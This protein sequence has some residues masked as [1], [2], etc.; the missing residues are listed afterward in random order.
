MFLTILTEVYDLQSILL[1]V[2]NFYTKIISL[3]KNSQ[4]LWIIIQKYG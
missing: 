4:I 3:L 2:N 1:S